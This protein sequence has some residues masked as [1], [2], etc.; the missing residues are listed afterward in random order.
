MRVD[1][2]DPNSNAA[3]TRRMWADWGWAVLRTFEDHLSGSKSLLLVDG[4][5]SYSGAR[6]DGLEGF[7][8]LALLRAFL[9]AAATHGDIQSP[10]LAVFAD[11]IR[12]GLHGEPSERWPSPQSTPQ[13]VV[14]ASTILLALR[15]LGDDFVRS[16]DDEVLQSLAR[17]AGNCLVMEIPDNNWH[18][19]RYVIASTLHEWGFGDD[20]RLSSARSTTIERLNRWE[21]SDGWYTD[22]DGLRVD[23]YNAWSFHFYPGLLTL[24]GDDSLRLDSASERSAIFLDSLADMIDHAGRPVAF[25]RSLIYRYAMSAAFSVNQLIREA[26]Q[27]APLTRD[28]SDR[29]LAAFA[30]ANQIPGKPGDLGW[31]SVDSRIAQPYSGPTSPLWVSKA[32]VRLLAPPTAELWTAGRGTDDLPEN[33]RGASP[34]TTI[35]LSKSGG[36]L[37]INHGTAWGRST[38]QLATPSPLY[39]QLSFSSLRVPLEVDELPAHQLMLTGRRWVAHRIVDSGSSVRY[40]AASQSTMLI[41]VSRRR[42]RSRLSRLYERFPALSPVKGSAGTLCSVTARVSGT[43]LIVHHLSGFEPL[44]RL[45]YT[46]P[47]WE[48]EPSRD[49]TAIQASTG[50]SEAVQLELEKV[51]A[52]SSSVDAETGAPVDCYVWRSVT[53]LGGDGTY[54]IIESMTIEGGGAA[55]PSRVKAISASGTQLRLR[56]PVL[57]MYDVFT[58]ANGFLSH[59]HEEGQDV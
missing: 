57:Q 51:R 42:V 36:T 45:S 34:F 39:D 12:A 32:F 16:L 40:P 26:N 1:F 15:I 18:F 5:P 25:G 2:L 19:F 20:D 22:G 8:R 9:H 58:L 46:V 56:S 23:Y 47:D 24:L 7:A 54:W 17:W 28:P 29:I 44:G 13:V 37:A 3:A 53:P 10:D 43:L 21:L 31:L 55:R 49:L 27:Q 4:R 48:R 41:H 35:P 14:E 52:R 59:S 38:H 6:S 33:M 50:S 30:R 11:G